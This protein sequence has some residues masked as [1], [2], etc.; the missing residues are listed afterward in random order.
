MTTGPTNRV[1]KVPLRD[2]RPHEQQ[3]FSRWLVENIDLL[4]EHLPFNVDPD[5]LQREQAAGD[6]AVDVVGEA[7][8]PDSTEPFN[9]VI[10]NQLERTDHDHLGKVLTYL[11]AYRRGRRP[12]GWG[13]RRR[14]P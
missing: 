8:G 12:S 2:A 7:T 4:N 1:E 6:F 3:D 11:A 13:R 14:G 10:E 5:S 9:V